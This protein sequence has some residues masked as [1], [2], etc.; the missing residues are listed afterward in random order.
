MTEPATGTTEAPDPGTPPAEP[1]PEQGDGKD[2]KAEHDKAL[3]NSRK[4]EDRAKANAGAAKELEELRKQAMSDQERAVAEAQ[5]AGR[6]EALS[7]VA[8]EI[9][10]ARI[11][12]AAAGRMQE[13]QLATLLEGLD[14][15]RFLTGDGKVDLAKVQAFVDGIAPAAEP[16]DPEFPDL[17]QGAQGQAHA[18]NGDPM[19]R[20]IQSKV[21]GR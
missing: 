9:V 20:A 1:E 8:S 16:G 6:A 5:A 2:W 19:L 10:D 14:R 11:E 3:A 12:A 18:L 15:T 17:G 4:W 7:E 13:T 21:G